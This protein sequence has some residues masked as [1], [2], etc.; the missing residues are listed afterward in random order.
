MAWDASMKRGALVM[1]RRIS[2]IAWALGLSA[3]VHG[4][5]HGTTEERW[6]STDEKWLS[7]MNAG[8]GL[9]VID[10]TL[11]ATSL[12]SGSPRECGSVTIDLGTNVDGRV[13]T[14]RM[15]A[16]THNII[17]QGAVLHLMAPMDS[18]EY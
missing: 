3:I 15:I 14:K 13:R 17:E 2:I 11:S 7:A 8:Q 5:A 9:V 12:I 6:R 18:G 10:A 16:E 1:S 4:C